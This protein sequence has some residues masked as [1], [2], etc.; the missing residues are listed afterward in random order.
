MDRMDRIILFWIAAAWLAL[1]V[2]GALMLHGALEPYL[3]ALIMVCGALATAMLGA[4]YWI[5]HTEMRRRAQAVARLEQANFE[6]N[7]LDLLVE[8]LQGSESAEEV[9]V[10]TTPLLISLF[11]EMHGSLALLDGSTELLRKRLSFGD[12]ESSPDSFKPSDCWA[13]RRGR[14][15]LAH[16]ASATCSH[17]PLPAGGAGYCVPLAP[18]GRLLGLLSLAS[19]DPAALDERRRRLAGMVAEQVGLSLA[20]LA[21]REKLLEQSQVDPLTGLY[22]RRRMA[23]AFEHERRS[24]TRDGRRF[25]L[26]MAD[27]DHFKA[28]NDRFGHEAGDQVLQAISDALRGAVRP[29]DIISRFGGEELVV[30]LPGTLAPEALERAEECRQA[31]E[32]LRLLHAGRD[33]GQVSISVGV[34]AYPGDGQTMDELLRHADAGLYDAKAQGRNRVCW[35]GRAAR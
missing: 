16:G 20:N 32:G 21:L 6:I 30:L 26:L 34:A 5:V 24:A 23:E 3:V 8:T 29:G 13:L 1:A 25:A 22:N 31:V 11:P 33:L 9:C 28:F 10:T 18:H 2:G 35:H 15:H 27:I 19:P 7:Q 17:L 12:P 14:P 4:M